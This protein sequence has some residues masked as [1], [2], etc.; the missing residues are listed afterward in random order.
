[1][2][3]GFSVRVD[4][5]ETWGGSPPSF[6]GARMRVDQAQLVMDRARRDLARVQADVR[7]LDR[8]KERPS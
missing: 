5:P 1:M 2:P 4:P 7:I 6:Q 3:I 8:R